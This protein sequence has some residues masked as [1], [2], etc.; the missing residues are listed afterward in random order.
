MAS[1]RL[2]SGDKREHPSARL[3]TPALGSPP[4]GTSFALPPS[5]ITA[6]SGPGT[7]A[8]ATAAA[9]APTT[10]DAV[11]AA[12]AAP[13]TDGPEVEEVVGLGPCLVVSWCCIR[14]RALSMRISASASSHARPSSGPPETT[15]L[16]LEVGGAP[17]A[18]G[19]SERAVNTG[20]ERWEGRYLW[21]CGRA[22]GCGDQRVLVVRWK[23]EINGE[24]EEDIKTEIQRH[25][26]R[27]RE[28]E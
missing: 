25:R 3:G 18:I 10:A 13:G 5:E 12:G 28:R 6:G 23:R 14:D 27:D 22:G 1:M 15:V 21:A 9:V 20:Q 26:H 2:L 19:K 17:P 8:P 4:G 7:A 16:L 24:R 11:A